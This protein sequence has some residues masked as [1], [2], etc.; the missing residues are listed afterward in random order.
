MRSYIMILLAESLATCNENRPT[1]NAKKEETK[2]D[3]VNV[4]ILKK[5]SV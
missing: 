4:F 5:D 1:V 3:S 2:V